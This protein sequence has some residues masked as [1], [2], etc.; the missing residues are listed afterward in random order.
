MIVTTPREFFEGFVPN[1]LDS[2]C[3]FLP[4]DV[5][6]AFY[7]DGEHGGC[8]QLRRSEDGSSV[9]PA[10]DGRKDCEM[11]CDSATFMRLVQ[12]SL[13]SNRAFLTGQLRI[14]GD[15]GL[16]LALEGFLREAA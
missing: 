6:V 8:W 9:G 2:V 3:S 11:W 1:S 10:L 5:V 7:I 13:G 15:V 16:A 4:E 14:S 12:G